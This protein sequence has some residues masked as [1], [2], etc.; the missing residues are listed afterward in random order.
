MTV[1]RLNVSDGTYLDFA[2]Y[3]KDIAE[4][5]GKSL[6]YVVNNCGGGRDAF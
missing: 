2:F 6:T 4:R 1:V 3:D 5:V